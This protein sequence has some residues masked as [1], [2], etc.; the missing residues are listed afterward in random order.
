MEDTVCCPRSAAKMPAS[1]KLK[2]TQALELMKLANNDSAMQRSVGIAV[3]NALSALLMREQGIEGARIMKGADALDVIAIGRGDTV[4]MVGA[5][6]P[7]IK[8]LKGRTKALYIIDKHPQAL[9]EDERPFR[10]SRKR[11]RYKRGAYHGRRRRPGCDRHRPRR[12]DRNGGGIC[13]FLKEERRRST[14]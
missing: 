1:G 14:L 3:L 13:S 9:K 10:T 8:Q 5:F 4:A 11:G 6:V 12:H 2:G 7:F